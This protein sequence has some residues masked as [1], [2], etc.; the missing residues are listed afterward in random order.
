MSAA[1]NPVVGA[2]VRKDG[3]LQPVAGS[4]PSTQW[5]YRPDPIATKPATDPPE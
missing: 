3:K 5:T 2:V 4:D 1:T